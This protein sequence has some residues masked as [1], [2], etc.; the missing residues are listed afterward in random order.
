MPWA[1]AWAGWAAGDAVGRP[2]GV[3]SRRRSLPPLFLAGFGLL[4][5]LRG[6]GR[7]SEV[8]VGVRR[9]QSTPET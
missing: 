5:G 3:L 9:D 7:R 1:W 4:G 8:F 2:M 6:R